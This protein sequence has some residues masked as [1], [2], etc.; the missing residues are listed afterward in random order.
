MAR[1]QDKE[2]AINMRK[3]GMSYSQIKEV[4][5]VSK[6]TLS[7]WLAPYPLSQERIRE[8]RDFNPR[9]IE[10]YRN[11]MQKKREERFKRF[12]E[13]AKR[14]IVKLSKREL[15]I[16]GLALYWGE[17]GKTKPFELSM[18][19]TDPTVLKYFIKWLEFLGAAP[20]KV[21]VRLQLYK[22]MNDANEVNY[23]SKQLLIPGKN[24]RKSYI[25]TSKQSDL[26][27][28]Q[29]HHHGTCN[30]YYCDVNMAVRVFASMKYLED[31]IKQ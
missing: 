7:G 6:G 8:L 1:R 25:K 21:K 28:K 31:M 19:N 29:R 4:L 24:F 12:Y 22:D 20:K 11:T 2:K 10:N 5:G 15:F 26:S 16:F 30:I 23:W 3:G 27:Y 14:E 9:R 13:V 17:G 18:S